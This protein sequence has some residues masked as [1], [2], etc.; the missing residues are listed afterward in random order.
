MAR[1]IQTEHW[2]GDFAHE[3]ETK[4]DPALIVQLADAAKARVCRDGRG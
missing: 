3:I 1:R 2:S 4:T